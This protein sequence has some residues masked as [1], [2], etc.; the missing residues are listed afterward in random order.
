VPVALAAALKDSEAVARSAL[1]GRR[2][3]L[4]AVVL[5]EAARS[6]CEQDALSHAAAEAAARAA[7]ARTAAAEERRRRERPKRRGRLQ[8]RRKK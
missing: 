4:N 5:T 7:L 8:S 1:A 6:A 3:A 2:S